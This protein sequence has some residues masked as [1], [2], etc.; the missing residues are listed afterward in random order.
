MFGISKVS[1]KAKMGPIMLPAVGLGVLLVLY[2]VLANLVTGNVLVKYRE[3]TAAT[4]TENMLADKLAK[5]SEIGSQTTRSVDTAIVALPE[6]NSTLLAM[7]QIKRLAQERA[8]VVSDFKTKSVAVTADNL[9]KAEL[10]F[11]V[12]AP[13][14]SLL[15]SFLDSMRAVAPLLVLGDMNLTANGDL[16]AGDISVI[17]HW[18]EFP[19]SLP[20]TG[21]P[22]VQ[23]TAAEQA[24]LT[25]LQNLTP[26]QIAGL[27]PT[28]P[29]ARDNPFGL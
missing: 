11:T 1:L 17:T 21:A 24:T 3:L 13:D 28:Q 27:Q 14:T 5:L 12:A 26:P 19:E 4:I 22:L 6:A 18:A 29:T 23:L 8:I 25:A 2:M 9:G 16:L 15:L 10:T 20:A 7:A